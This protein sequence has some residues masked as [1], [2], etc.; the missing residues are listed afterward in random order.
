[1]SDE[2]VKNN[3]EGVIR[4]FYDRQIYQAA[5]GSS[6][7]EWYDQSGHTN[8]L[9][10]RNAEKLLYGRVDRYYVPIFLNSNEIA[11]TP[12]LSTGPRQ[13]RLVAASFVADAFQDLAMQFQKNAMMG[14][15]A[16]EE[17]YLTTLAPE[18][19]YEDP[20]NLYYVYSNKII[21]VLQ[22]YYADNNIEFENFDE[23]LIHL[24]Q[25][26]ASTAPKFPITF[27]AYMK[28]R[29]CPITCTGLAIEIADVSSTDDQMKFRDFV[30]TT[31]WKFYVNACRS[32]GFS[33]DLNNPWR[34][35][36]DI[37]SSEMLKYARKQGFLNTSDIL[38][39]GYTPAHL[40]FYRGFKDFLLTLYNSLRTETYTRIEYCQDGRA[41]PKI[42]TAQTYMLQDIENMHSESFFID[43]YCH[44]RFLEEE[45]KFSSHEQVNIIRDCVELYKLRGI[46]MALR[47]FEKIINR[48]YSYSGSLTD[49]ATRG[50]LDQE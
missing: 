34:I 14:K 29:Y 15:I 50:I 8:V 39:T 24:K 23:F 41:I 21:G 2:F 6:Y 9:D 48:T 42:I 27:P 40:V 19:A 46:E 13:S 4:L 35:I 26:L 37:G 28:S 49:R 1:M 33:V 7:P 32:Y 22:E 10:F 31:N 3:N 16:S 47:Q 30:D 11:I 44:I 36:A 5:A 38:N 17:L 43:L 45:N 12:L 18:K 20:Q 25:S